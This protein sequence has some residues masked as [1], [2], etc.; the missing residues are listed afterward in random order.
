MEVFITHFGTATMLIEIGS[1]RLLTDPVF[2]APGKSYNVLGMARYRRQSL[3]GAYPS[4][5]EGCDAVLLSHDHHGDNLDDAGRRLL[6]SARACYTTT[7]AARNLGGHAVGLKVWQQAE[8][9]GSQGE[10]VRITA[11]P[12]QHGPRWMNPLTGPV[13]GFVLEWDGQRDGALYISGDTVLFGGIAEVAKRFPVGTAILHV[14]RA[15]FK[16]TGALHYTFTA[17]ESAQAAQ[18]LDARRIYP[19]HYEGWSH[20]R[21]GRADVER[22][23]AQAGWADRLNF[24][25]LGERYRLEPA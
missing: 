13:T 18:V 5:L 2:D 25:P 6:A 8:L 15:S 22:A 11:T 21:E 23:F 7:A 4:A 19:I 17:Q 3:P 20:F 12:A 14:G 24:F 16:G 1:L 10:R 9:T